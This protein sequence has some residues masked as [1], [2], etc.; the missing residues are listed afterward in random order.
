MKKKMR[1][2]KKK[3]ER[4]AYIPSLASTKGLY[5]GFH[6]MK[7]ILYPLES[8]IHVSHIRKHVDEECRSVTMNIMIPINLQSN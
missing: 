1:R 7:C 5:I 2:R 4:G 8:V 6:M 3:K